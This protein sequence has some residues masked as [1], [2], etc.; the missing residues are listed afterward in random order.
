MLTLPGL[1]PEIL[2]KIGCQLDA[3]DL[4]R[5]IRANRRLAMVLCPKLQRMAIDC[6]ELGFAALLSAASNGNI[7]LVK[8]Y[9][10]HGLNDARLQPLKGMK[11]LYDLPDDY[12]P[13]FPG[14]LFSRNHQTAFLTAAMES[15]E[16][17][18]KVIYET[19]IQKIVS[20]NYL[21]QSALHMAASNKDIGPLEYLIRN[22]ADTNARDRYKQTPLHHAAAGWSGA[23]HKHLRTLIRNGARVDA[24]DFR[25]RTPLHMACIG[26]SW[27]KIKTLL[28]NQADI[29][30]M[31][32]N[33]KVDRTVPE[34]LPEVPLSLKSYNSF[35]QGL[36]KVGL[37]EK[38]SRL[39]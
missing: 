37:E 23:S 27:P 29:Q 19:G 12:T 21:R 22:G 34:V 33:E 25:K 3:K 17:T 26:G 35:L 7:L 31:A 10:N 5:L 16:T 6:P 14:F 15:N 20:R 8:L 2:V 38:V 24:L 36:E 30:S 4:C 1:P 18:V 11:R 9:I 28:E 32:S 13:F 39:F